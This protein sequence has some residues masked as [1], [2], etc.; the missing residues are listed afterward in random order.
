MIKNSNEFEQIGSILN[1]VLKTYRQETDEELTKVWKLWDSVVGP[2]I[3][4]NVRPAA[5]KEKILLVHA[6]NPIWIQHLQFFKKDIITK[7]NTVVDK[8]LVKDIKFKI[9]PL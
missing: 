7:L 3:A 5:F 2:A 9:G 6:T 4:K 8:E 1:K